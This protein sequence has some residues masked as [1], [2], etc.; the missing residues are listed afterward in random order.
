MTTP[1]FSRKYVLV[2]T[3]DGRNVVINPPMQ[4]VFEVTKSIHGGLNKMNIQNN[5]TCL[6][7]NGYLLSKM[8]SSGR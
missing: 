5:K 4:I 6:R 8:P 3:A 1:R 2:I 7:I